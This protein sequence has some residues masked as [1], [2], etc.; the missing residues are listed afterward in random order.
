LLAYEHL[1]VTISEQ[2]FVFNPESPKPLRPSISKLSA[3]P[4]EAITGDRSTLQGFVYLVEPA[5][6]PNS[7]ALNQTGTL[8]GEAVTWMIMGIS[9]LSVSH[10]DDGAVRRRL[11]DRPAQDGT[12]HPVSDI[13]R[14][15][16]T[17]H[18]TSLR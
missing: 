9:H 15:R 11:A 14:A 6:Q 3:H 8:Y 7:V 17:R 10:P 12:V 13:A 2:V 18:S 5:H 1:F 16:L 4:T